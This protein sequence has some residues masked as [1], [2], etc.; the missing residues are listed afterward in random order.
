MKSLF[1]DE[2]YTEI[3]K[4]LKTLNSE[5]ER[6]WGKMD[7]GQALYHCQQPLNVSLGRGDV[8]KQFI[9]L[10]FLFKKSLYNDK[11]WRQNLPTAKT[12]KIS[13]SKDFATE[14]EALETLVDEFHT[15]KNQTQWD[16]HPIF[17]KFTPQQCGQ[18]QYKHLDHHLK[19]FGA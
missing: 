9:P 12:F 8:K 11:P 14:Q 4:R 16:P 3:K 17:G 10:A 2:A 18:M 15:K 1:D 13:E 5:S 6:K 19:Q 7:I